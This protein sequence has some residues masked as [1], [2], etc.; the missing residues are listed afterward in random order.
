MQPAADPL[1]IG[2]AF[3]PGGRDSAVNV[4]SRTRDASATYYR[5]IVVALW[6]ARRHHPD[7]DLRLFTTEDVP[8]E[9][10]DQLAALEVSTVCVPFS[11]RPNPPLAPSFE[12]S[13]YTLDVIEH[14]AEA[15]PD[16]QVVLIDPDC[17]VVGPLSPA[18]SAVGRNAV[19]V[20]DLEQPEDYVANGLSRADAELIHARIGGVRQSAAV[21]PH[22][23]GEF[24]LFGAGS[25]RILV[26]HVR[27]AY[28]YACV[29]AVSHPGF[30]RPRM[31]TEEHIL[32]YAL[33]FVDKVSM[34]DHVARIWTAPRLRLVPPHWSSLS[35]WHLPA[36]KDRGFAR[37]HQLVSDSPAVRLSTAELATMMG[38]SRRGIGRLAYDWVGK[39]ARAVSR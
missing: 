17:L 29:D 13:L 26:D 33:R 37:C 16:R 14:I 5:C 15:L 38:V 10:G 39:A 25:A 8:P 23:G 30:L 6:S 18:A 19:G 21:S 2:V 3:V 32:N 7:A 31:S 20:L 36:E 9:Y 1:V 35:V 34:L 24:Y 28:A 11:Y 12:A 22:F 4:R 27:A